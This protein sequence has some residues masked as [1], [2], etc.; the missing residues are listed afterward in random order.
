[1]VDGQGRLLPGKRRRSKARSAFMAEDE[2]A[3]ISG[4]L[5]APSPRAARYCLPP[6]S[7]RGG[8]CSTLHSNTYAGRTPIGLGRPSTVGPLDRASP[9]ENTV[10]NSKLRPVASPDTWDFAKLGGVSALSPSALSAP[11]SVR[12]LGAQSQ[13]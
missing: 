13:S 12:R 5:S 4:A 7:G 3:S 2:L 9:Y 6:L 11:A 8:R 1:M 10:I